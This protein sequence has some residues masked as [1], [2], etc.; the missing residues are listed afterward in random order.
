MVQITVDKPRPGGVSIKDF[1]KPGTTVQLVALTPGADGG[2]ACV[3][4]TNPQARP[5]AVKVPAPDQVEII[6]LEA[7]PR[8]QQPGHA[9]RQG[10]FSDG[11]CCSFGS[12][13]CQLCSLVVPLHARPDALPASQEALALPQ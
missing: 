10:S 4:W 1:K 2:L 5:R 6:C 9:S 11:A 12:W 7:L 3:Q 8:T 13:R